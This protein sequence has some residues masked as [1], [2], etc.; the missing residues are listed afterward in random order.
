LLLCSLPGDRQWHSFCKS[1]AVVVCTWFH[2]EALPFS[3]RRLQNWWQDRQW[4]EGFPRSMYDPML[5]VY[6]LYSA[7]YNHYGCWF[8]SSL[9]STTLLPLMAGQT[10]KWGISPFHV[11][12]NAISVSLCSIRHDHRKYFIMNINYVWSRTSATWTH[13]PGPQFALLQLWL[14]H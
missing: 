7:I 13:A 14:W 3:A 6:L 12:T 5:S 2:H 11:W 10:I 9:L 4:N 1:A 8:L